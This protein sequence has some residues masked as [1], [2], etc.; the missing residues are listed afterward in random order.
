MLTLESVD[1]ELWGA[2]DS[3]QES[4]ESAAMFASRKAAKVNLVENFTCNLFSVILYRVHICDWKLEFI[5]VIILCKCLG[6][7]KI[8]FTINSTLSSRVRGHLMPALL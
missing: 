2:A 7:I 8:K 3:L 1:G 6:G 4:R 5:H